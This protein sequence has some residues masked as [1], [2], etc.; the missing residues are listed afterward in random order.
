[1][2]DC[3]TDGDAADVEWIL[4][5]LEERFKCKSDAMFTNLLTQDYLEMAIRV[6]GGRIYMSM[7]KYMKNAWRILEITGESWVPINQP[8]DMDSPVLSPKRKT[9]FLT[10]TGMLGW[11]AL[12]VRCDVSYTYSR[13]TQQSASP[14][15]SAMKAVRT[16][17]AY[18]NKSK[19]FCI[20]AQIHDDNDIVDIM[21]TLDKCSL[22]PEEWSFM[23]DSDHAGNAHEVQNKRRSQNGLIIKLNEAP[24]MCSSKASSLSQHHALV[25]L[26]LI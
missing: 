1:M 3:L 26:M 7:A 22:E 15:E 20:S 9:E 18:P 23:V 17:F 24:V 12:T 5:K 25:R 10:A 13:I 16:A 4:T 14:T 8:I 6:E 11:L 19:H 2:D 21:A